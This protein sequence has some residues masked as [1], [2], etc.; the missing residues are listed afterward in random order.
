ML[1]LEVTNRGLELSI[2]ADEFPIEVAQ[3]F[4]KRLADQTEAIMFFEAP[5]KTG[6]LAQSIVKQVNNLEA[7]VGPLVIYAGFVETGTSPHEIRPIRVRVLAFKSAEGKMV[8][9]S[10][11]HHPGTKANPFM[12][13]TLEQVKENASSVFSD[14]WSNFAGDSSS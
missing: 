9:S 13:R 14:V 4:I 10:L 3:K 6:K 2:V 1:E 12:H 7:N 5:W 8:F 11:V